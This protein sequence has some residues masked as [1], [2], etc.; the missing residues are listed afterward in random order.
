MKEIEFK[1][2][3]S[4]PR[5]YSHFLV[6]LKKLNIKIVLLKSVKIHDFYL[7]TSDRFFGSSRISC[8]IRK[9]DSRWELTFK[10]RTPLKQGLAMRTEKNISLK[11]V[12][13]FLQALQ[14]CK[15]LLQGILSDP[16]IIKIFEI[17]NMRRRYK[18]I[19]SKQTQAMVCFDKVWIQKGSQKVPLQEIELEFLKGNLHTYYEFIHKMVEVCE[20]EP[21]KV[22]KVATAI[23][24]FKLDVPEKKLNQALKNR[25]FQCNKSYS[26]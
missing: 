9:E 25:I 16:V 5:D 20:L 21:A 22:S 17:K 26:I 23:K 24:T 3:V 4:S 19:L 1:W 2:A 13:T 10:T 18:I 7:D 15:K 14:C 11:R 6:V 8:R 12:K